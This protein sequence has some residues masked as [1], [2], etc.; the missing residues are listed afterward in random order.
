VLKPSKNTFS[1]RRRRRNRGVGRTA[2]RASLG[3]KVIKSLLTQLDGRFDV[4]SNMP[5]GV[6]GELDVPLEQSTA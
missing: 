5:K 4:A 6:T 2:R 3:F 1:L